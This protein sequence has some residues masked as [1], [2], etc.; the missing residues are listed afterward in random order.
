MQSVIEKMDALALRLSQRH[1]LLASLIGTILIMVGFQWLK[2]QLGTAMLDEM[3]GYDRDML[4]EQMLIFGEAGRRLH[5][6]FTLSLDMIF[7]PVYGALFAGLLALAARGLPLKAIAAPVIAVMALD[8]A[9]NLQLAML[10]ANY[11]ELTTAQIEAASATTVAKFWAI[12]F[13]LYWLVGLVLWRLINTLRT[14]A[15]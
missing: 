11:P 14:R 2:N 10:L 13:T 4:D 6:I 9:E 15:G 12:R 1:F 8:Y 3:A 5:M 7:P